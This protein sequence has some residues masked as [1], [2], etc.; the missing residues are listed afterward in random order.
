MLFPTPQ[1]HKNVLLQSPNSSPTDT[2]LRYIVKVL[3]LVKISAKLIPKEQSS[4]KKHIMKQLARNSGEQKVD[5]LPRRTGLGGVFTPR[6]C[7]SCCSV[8]EPYRS[9]TMKHKDRMEADKGFWESIQR[10]VYFLNNLRS[11]EERVIKAIIG[12]IP[13]IS[14]QSVD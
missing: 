4:F 1:P 14:S 13:R 8:R 2:A 5:T 3:Q 7:S 12:A 9:R 10:K 11:R 6:L